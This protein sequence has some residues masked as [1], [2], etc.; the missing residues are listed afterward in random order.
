MGREDWAHKAIRAL[1]A[2]AVLGALSWPAAALAG[3]AHHNQ[4]HLTVPKHARASKP[5]AISLQ[6]YAKTKERLYLFLDYAKCGS[7]PSIEHGAHGAN[8][9]YW[10][11]K[12]PFHEVSNGWLSKKTGKDH[13][14]AYLQP[15]SDPLNSPADV[16]ARAAARYRIH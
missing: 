13:A 12:G 1:V 9:V 3:G 16:R 6:G 4:I 10:T 2:G 5:Y 15:I 8:G 14:C 11:V 7:N